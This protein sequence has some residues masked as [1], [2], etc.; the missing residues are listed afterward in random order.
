MSSPAMLDAVEN[1]SLDAALLSPPPRIPRGLEA[2][3]RFADEFVFIAPPDMSAPPTGKA[4]S[5]CRLRGLASGLPWL[6]LETT[7]QTG[8]GLRRWMKLHGW[9]GEPAMELDGFDPIVNLVALGLGVSFVPHR[10]LALYGARRK[11]R[12][13]VT[14]PRF[15][16]ELAVVVRRNRVQPPP[17]ADFLASVLFYT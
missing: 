8:R 17:L 6:L 2:T 7:S 4:I 13:I 5:P 11:V 14:R 3:H 9:I 1:G 12:R 16:R 10:V 15:S